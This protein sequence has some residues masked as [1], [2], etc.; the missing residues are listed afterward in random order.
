MSTTTGTAVFKR[1]DYVI[2]TRAAY[3]IRGR[4]TA[5]RSQKHPGQVR[6]SFKLGSYIS[7]WVSPEATGMFRD[8]LGVP[9]PVKETTAH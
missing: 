4:I 3:Q 5:A 8:P 7:R 1:G 9:E 2:F 6:V